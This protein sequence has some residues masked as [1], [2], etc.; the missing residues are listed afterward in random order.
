MAMAVAATSSQSSIC[1]FKSRSWPTPTNGHRSRA[2]HSLCK[3]SSS[4][5]SIQGTEGSVLLLS[6]LARTRGRSSYPRHY[7]PVC[8][9]MAPER[10]ASE[11]QA[12]QMRPDAFGR[13]GKYG[14]KYVPETLMHAL[15][16]L[17]SAFYMLIKDQG[18]QVITLICSF[19]HTLLFG[20]LWSLVRIPCNHDD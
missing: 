15:S 7:P 8:C 14:G 6:A 10:A 13:F 3:W 2:P 11:G 1:N 16:E 18:F 17:E 9:T 12:V 4:A 20:F 19:L 5:S